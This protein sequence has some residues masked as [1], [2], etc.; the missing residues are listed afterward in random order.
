MANECWVF[1][2]GDKNIKINCG[3]VCTTF[4]YTR[5]YQIVHFKWVSYRVCELDLS[6]AVVKNV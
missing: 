4:K 3:G 1:L 6:K 5:S 2:W